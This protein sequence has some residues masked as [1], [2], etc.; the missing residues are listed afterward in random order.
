M[1]SSM[2]SMS[3]ALAFAV[4]WAQCTPVSAQ[5]RG[6]RVGDSRAAPSASMPAGHAGMEV[7][8]RGPIHEAFAEP[9]NAG[10]VRPLVVPKQPPAPIAEA[11]PEERPIGGKAAW[12]GGYWSWDDDRNDFLWV[13]GTWRVPP[14]DRRWIPG[15]W[16]QV[17][18]GFEWVPGF[19]GS[20]ENEEVAYYPEPPEAQDEAPVGDPPTPDSFWVPGCWQWSDAGYAWQAGYWTAAQPGWIWMPASY[21]WSPRGWIFCDGYWDYPLTQRGLAFAPVYFAGGARLGPRFSY[22]PS[23]VID[24]TLLTFSLFVRPSYGHYYFGDYYAARYDGLGIFPWFSVFEHGH[25]AYDPIFSY[26]GWYNRSRDP[27]WLANLRTWHEHYRAHADQRPPHDVMAARS[28]AARSE[29]RADHQ[30]LSIA[31]PL[32]DWR[33]RADAPVR[34]AAVSAADR[35]TIEATAR[36]ERDFQTHRARLESGIAMG[37]AAEANRP[38]TAAR[39][40]TLKAPQK[41]ALPQP[42][43]RVARRAERSDTVTPQPTPAEK[44]GPATPGGVVPRVKPSPGETPQRTPGAMPKTP[45]RPEG[46]GGQPPVIEGPRHP[47][48]PARTPQGTAPREP[49]QPIAP[50]PSPHRPENVPSETRKPAPPPQTPHGENPRPAPERAPH[51]RE[52]GRK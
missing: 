45:S 25:Y 6:G 34:L 24:P 29:G 43:P 11:I 26:Y 51:E 16:T 9:V 10:A 49:R 40:P 39:A 3:L 21:C 28:L 37:G 8:N 17:Q 13:S 4:A 20:E 42:T 14:P 15:Y 12:I 32:Q 23:V 52:G 44:G 22:A 47:A 46:R 31:Q 27:Q 38:T 5:E 35:T 2:F 33:A 30:F 18:S 50:A 36:Q 48:P 19:W 7:M 1:R 41:M